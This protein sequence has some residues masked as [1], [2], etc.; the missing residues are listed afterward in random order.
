MRTP[1]SRRWVESTTVCANCGSADAIGIRLRLNEESE[2]DFHSCHH[3]EHRWWD[4][5]GEVID[6]TAVL[7]RARRH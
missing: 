7:D 5:D 4:C 1:R 6:L 2:V 3:C